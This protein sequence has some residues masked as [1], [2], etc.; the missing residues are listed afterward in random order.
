MLTAAA[1]GELSKG[2]FSPAVNANKR[3][4]QRKV[5]MYSLTCNSIKGTFSRR[6]LYSTFS[7]T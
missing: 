4:N 2:T 6:P 5:L 1:L 7:G 3:P